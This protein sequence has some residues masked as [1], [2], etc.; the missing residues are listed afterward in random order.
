MQDAS[1]AVRICSAQISSV[2]EDPEHSLE[3][4]GLFIRH[5]AVSGASLICFPEQFATGWDPVSGRNIQDTSGTIVSGLREYAKQNRISILGSFRQG[6]LKKPRNTAIAIDQTGRIT[7]MYSKIHLFG[8]ANEPSGYEPGTGLG[9][10][11]VGPLLCGI[12]ICYDLRFPEIFRLYREKGAHAVLVPAAWPAQRLKHW[13]LFIT[14]RAVENQMYVA[15]VNTTGV[16]PVDIYAGSS[17]TADP[18][19][20]II[21]RANEAEQLVFSDID[22][23]IVTSARLGFPVDHDRKDALYQSLSHEP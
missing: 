9:L 19:G 23:E 21:S 3:K 4:A 15:G 5:A 22:P 8:P 2:W 20:T 14:A 18:H 1:T 12:A 6:G 10:F 16:T 11:S 13:E 7:T 17:M